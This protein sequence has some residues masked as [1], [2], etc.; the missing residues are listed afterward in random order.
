MGSAFET[1]GVSQTGIQDG[2]RTEGTLWVL[3]L[4]VLSVPNWDTEMAEGLRGLRGLC[5]FWS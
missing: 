4:K 1:V 5:G 2:K 3:E